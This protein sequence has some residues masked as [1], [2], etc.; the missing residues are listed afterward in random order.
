[1]PDINNSSATTRG[2][3]KSTYATITRTMPNSTTTTKTRGNINTLKTFSRSSTELSL[4]GQEAKTEV[5]PA[6]LIKYVMDRQDKQINNLIT[7]QSN[8]IQEIMDKQQQTI[9]EPITHITASIPNIVTKVVETLLPSIIQQV[10]S[11]LAQDNSD[12]SSDS[13]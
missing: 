11:T 9:Q 8:T 10:K 6:T 5:T 2:K 7:A 1:M 12:K 13:L 4:R 3:K